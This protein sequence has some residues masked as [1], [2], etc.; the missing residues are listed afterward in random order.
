MS[1][2]LQPL[3]CPSPREALELGEP[4]EVDPGLALKQSLQGLGPG[5][6]SP[7]F[8]QVGGPALPEC[9]GPGLRST[10]EGPPSQP[11][12]SSLRSGCQNPQTGARRGCCTDFRH[13]LP[14]RCHHLGHQSLRVSETHSQPGKDHTPHGPDPQRCKVSVKR[15]QLGQQL[16]N[17]LIAQAWPGVL[18]EGS[19]EENNIKWLFTSCQE[20]HQRFHRRYG[21]P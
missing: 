19:G 13:R 8:L 5:L 17:L 3:P 15:E 20:L 11:S 1:P 9:P 14:G 21:L 7:C 12:F 2:T 18:G 6:G 4:L 16:L 10:P